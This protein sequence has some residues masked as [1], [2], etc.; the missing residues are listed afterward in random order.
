MTNWSGLEANELG[1]A[2]LQP[3]IIAGGNPKTRSFQE[4]LQIE[5]QF[6]DVLVGKIVERERLQASLGRP[7]GKEQACLSSH[8]GLTHVKSEFYL[9]AFIQWL[10]HMQKASAGGD[11]V[12][13]GAQLAAILQQQ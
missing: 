6:P 5:L 3:F 4:L 7:H 12:Q 10:I 8:C 2:A 11:L 13:A 1:S 9:D